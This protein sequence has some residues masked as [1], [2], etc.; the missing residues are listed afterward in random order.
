M[1]RHVIRYD[2]T[3][4]EIRGSRHVVDHDYQPEDNELFADDVRSRDLRG[5]KVDADGPELVPDPDYDPR[6]RIE[7][8]EDRFEHVLERVEQAEA[9]I[10]GT[11]SDDESG[12]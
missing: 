7:R 2:P 1:T 6:D 3:T 9:R 10:G 4:G 12:E 5:M 11:R 8:L